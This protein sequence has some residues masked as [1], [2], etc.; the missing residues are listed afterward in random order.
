MNLTWTGENRLRLSA[1]QIAILALVVVTGVAAVAPQTTL[2]G[3]AV[4]IVAAIGLTVLSATDLAWRR[5]PDVL[6]AGLT[7]A[8]LVAVTTAFELVPLARSVVGGVL[9]GAV[10]VG[11]RLLSPEGIGMGDVKLAPALGMLT[12]FFGWNA[13]FYGFV[14]AFI[15]N[16]LA[17]GLLVA[18]SRTP[19]AGKIAF[20]PSLAL[21]CLIAIAVS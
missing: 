12:A 9:A 15:L 4:A 10:F 11:L 20:G 6:V 19:H 16:G 17:G 8:T 1:V 5:L 2:G 18:T 3:T 13:L 7:T 21:C 14:A